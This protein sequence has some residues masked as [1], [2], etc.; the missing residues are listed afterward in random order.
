LLKFWDDFEKH[1]RDN[2]EWKEDTASNAR[3]ARNLLDRLW[4]GL[5]VAELLQSPVASDFKTKL[6][7]MPK[8]YSCGDW[9]TMTFQQMQAAVAKDASIP[10]IS[11][12]TVNKHFS[13]LS[14]Y[15]TYLVTKKQVSE[16]LK[17]PFFG[18]HTPPHLDEFLMDA[19]EK[20]L[21]RASQRNV[22]LREIKAAL[23]DR[24]P[25]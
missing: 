8:N 3:S 1:K 17:D 24:L 19:V 14:E 5:T 21:D 22:V 20:E 2:I 7:S 9:A 25:A 16:K 11:P 18:F 23:R 13:N 4:P 15:W 6:L 12:T 10:K